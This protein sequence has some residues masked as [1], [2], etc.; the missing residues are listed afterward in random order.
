MTCLISCESKCSD[1]SAV[2]L[3]ATVCAIS[4]CSH[5]IKMFRLLG[6]PSEGM[7]KELGGGGSAKRRESHGAA[8]YA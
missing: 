1:S 3:S 2:V 6:K 8:L 5:E 7:L 4:N